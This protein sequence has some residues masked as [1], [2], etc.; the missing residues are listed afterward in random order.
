M[1]TIPVSCPN[2]HS[3]Q[4]IKAGTQ[5]NGTQRYRCQNP[6]CE[7]TIFQLTYV[8]HGRLPET[9]RQIVQMVLNGSGIRDT[10]RALRVS[11]VTVLRVLKKEPN[12][13]SV[14]RAALAALTG[15]D[16]DVLLAR[17]QAAEI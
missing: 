11:P 15:A 3:T 13:C 4:I 8:A 1:A 17:V 5:P 14:N 16:T 10:A 12:L 9:Q 2:C 7:R 6:T